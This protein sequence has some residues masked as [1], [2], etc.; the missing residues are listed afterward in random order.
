MVEGAAA[1]AANDDADPT[2][3][4]NHD[5]GGDDHNNDTIDNDADSSNKRKHRKSHGKVGFVEMARLIGERWKSLKAEDRKV[6]EDE[7]KGLKMRYVE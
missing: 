1:E 7:A 4:K 6:Y 5:E 3:S 2:S